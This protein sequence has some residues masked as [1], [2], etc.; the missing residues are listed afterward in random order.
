[1][2]IKKLVSILSVSLLSLYSCTPPNNSSSSTGSSSNSSPSNTIGSASLNTVIKTKTDL[3]NAYK[4]AIDSTDN[5]G[6]KTQ[7]NI[8]LNT[9]SAIPETSISSIAID[10]HAKVLSQYNLSNCNLSTGTLVDLSTTPSSSPSPSPN[11]GNID[12][13]TVIKTKADLIQAYNCAIEATTDSL[14]KAQ[15]QIGLTTINALPDSIFTSTS[16]S[17]YINVLKAYNIEKCASLSSST[18]TTGSSGNSGT[19]TTGSTSAIVSNANYSMY[20]C[21]AEKTLVSKSGKSINVTFINNMSKAIKIYWLNQLGKRVSYNRNVP[22][23]GMHQ[24]QTYVTHPWV[25]TDSNDNCLGVYLFNENT[26]LTLKDDMTQ[27]TSSS[28]STSVN[29]SASVSSN[30]TAGTASLL[31]S[32]NNLARNSGVIVNVSSEYS[33]S[34]NKNRLIDGN[35]TTSW[36]SKAGDAANLGKSPYIELVFPNPVSIK[37]VNLK[38][39][40]E[41]AS[42]YDIFE[43]K[44]IVNSSSGSSNY[45]VSFP[46][47]ERD[48][49]ISFNQTISDV[50][51]IKLE[52]TKDESQDPGLAEFEVVAG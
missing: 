19:S 9:V 41:Y 24:Q 38:G 31:S 33:T 10:V 44:L 43:G 48:F 51:S 39:N 42:G 50:K 36:F 35:I 37:G 6:V 7:L 1:M 23:N 15:L 28:T 2:S 27:G 34:W 52:I 14:S 11:V 30:V 3:I 25:I 47:P 12:L 29:T 45:N 5:A 49:N 17:T 16:I 13:S 46:A 32:T 40:R 26:N 22:I 21:D 4:C 18:P 20:G 8:G